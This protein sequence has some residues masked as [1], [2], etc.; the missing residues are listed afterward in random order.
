MKLIFFCGVS[1]RIKWHKRGHVLWCHAL[2]SVIVWCLWLTSEP[3]A[4]GKFLVITGPKKLTERGAKPVFLSL[5]WSVAAVKASEKQ[6]LSGPFSLL[7]LCLGWNMHGNSAIFSPFWF[8]LLSARESDL[9][10]TLSFYGAE[11]WSRRWKSR[12]KHAVRALCTGMQGFN[13]LAGQS[14]LPV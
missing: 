7:S 2:A 12:G 11:W 4:N 5:K 13:F 6:E 9:P 3:S 8:P 10:L 14:S 1:V